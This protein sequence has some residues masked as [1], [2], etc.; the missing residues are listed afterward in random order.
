MSNNMGYYALLKVSKKEM[1]IIL[2]SKSPRR[3]EILEN[4]GLKFEI[5]VADADES[6]DITDPHL[7]V[8]TLAERK[9]RA[10]ADRLDSLDDTLIIASD[11]LVYAEG[12]FLGKPRDKDDA[13]RMIKMLSGKSHIVVSGIYLCFCGKEANGASATRVIF[14]EMTDAEIEHYI[15]SPEPYDKAGG[16]AVQGLAA[17]YINGL[18]GDYFNVVGLPVNLMCKMLKEEFGTNIFDLT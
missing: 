1:R 13:R 9:G 3:K 11:T 16:Y 4:L 10:V 18:E 6:S 2:A 14:D 8:S 12:E 17:V 7:L 15:S 5:I